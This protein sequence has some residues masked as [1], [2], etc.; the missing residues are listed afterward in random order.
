MTES[1]N[2]QIGAVA[3]IKSELHLFQIG[4]KMLCGNAMPRSGN[5][6]LQERERRFD[7]VCVN[8]P[9]NV[10]AGAVRDFLVCASAFS[11]SHGRIVRGCI[12]CKNHVYIFRDILADILCECA[13][14][15]IAGMKEAQVAVALAYTD[16][17]FLVVHSRYTALA[18]VPAADVGHIHFHF[19]VQHRFIGL[20]HGVTDAM[21]EIPCRL[22]AHSDRALNLAGRH[23]LLRLAKKMRSEK[24]LGKRQM[25]IVEYG[26]G[27]DSE[28]IIAILAVE[29]LLFSFKFDHGHLATRATRSFRP[30]QT[31]QQFAA[32]SLGWEERIYVH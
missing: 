18:L 30:A 15:R 4:R 22:V 29:K 11:L 26:A 17:H 9:H 31:D 1:V 14:L 32:L 20:R 2:K 19:S 16:Y 28:L 3:S 7:G 5:T 10:D 8:V 23:A 27:S 13:A 6:A 21:A 25:R 12:V 24:P